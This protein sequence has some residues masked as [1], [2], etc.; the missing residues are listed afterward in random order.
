M[1]AK[2]LHYQGKY[3]VQSATVRAVAYADQ[4]TTCWRCGRTL[5]EVKQIRPRARWTAGH[6]I[7]G[8]VDGPLAPE[9]SPCNYAAG[10]RLGNARRRRTPLS[11]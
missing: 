5:R 7:D 6:L 2:P 3:H 10:A 11:W 1:K 4:L 8:M 9:C